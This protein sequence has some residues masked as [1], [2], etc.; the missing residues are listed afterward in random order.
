[1]KSL[2]IVCDLDKDRFCCWGVYVVES[3]GK[4]CVQCLVLHTESGVGAWDCRNQWRQKD[5]KL[6]VILCCM[7]NLRSKWAT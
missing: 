6:K 3:V 4:P 1:M 5:R 7:L 2:E